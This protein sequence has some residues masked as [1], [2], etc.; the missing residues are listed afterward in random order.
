MVALYETRFTQT[1]VRQI[2]TIATPSTRLIDCGQF[3]F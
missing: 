3:E 2:E 1:G